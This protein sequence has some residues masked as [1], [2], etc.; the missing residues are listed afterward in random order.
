MGVQLGVSHKP[1]MFMV[2]LNSNKAQPMSLLRFLGQSCL[3]PGEYWEAIMTSSLITPPNCPF[4]LP[5][6][7]SFSSQ[8][9]L[10]ELRLLNLRA[11]LYLCE[12]LSTSN[13]FVIKLFSAESFRMVFVNRY[14]TCATRIARNSRLLTLRNISERKKQHFQSFFKRVVM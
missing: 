3:I 2:G 7:R 4:F 14:A 6:R 13:S 12:H 1:G 5:I 10:R 8:Y 9:F 11:L